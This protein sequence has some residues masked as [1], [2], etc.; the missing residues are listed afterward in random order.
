[1]YVKI[2]TPG[3][4][5]ETQERFAQLLVS[6]VI[7]P[8]VVEGAAISGLTADDVVGIVCEVLPHTEILIDGE[9]AN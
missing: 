4:T 8:N 1:M 2:A 9:P 3:V 7:T 6:P 5:R